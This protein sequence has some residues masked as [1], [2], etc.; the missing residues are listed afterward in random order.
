MKLPSEYGNS[1][2]EVL[3]A[4]ETELK[5]LHRSM[6]Q[7][8]DETALEYASRFSEVEAMLKD[9][10][11]VAE[12]QRLVVEAEARRKQAATNLKHGGIALFCFLLLLLVMFFASRS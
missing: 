9:V 11:K 6:R 12:D 5:A 8:P 7:K 2:P 4:Y 10:R 1:S 3:A